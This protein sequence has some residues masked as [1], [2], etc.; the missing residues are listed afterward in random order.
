MNSLRTKILFITV[1]FIVVYLVLLRPNLL[2]VKKRV[3][4]DETKNTYH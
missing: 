3:T 1:I 2:K 4:I